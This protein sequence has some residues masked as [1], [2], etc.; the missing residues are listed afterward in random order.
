MQFDGLAKFPGSQ[1]LAAGSP[2]NCVVCNSP[3]LNDD[4]D[5]FLGRKLRAVVGSYVLRGA[6]FYKQVREVV[7]HIIGSGAPPHHFA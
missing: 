4:L 3:L 1:A 6:M 5:L 7:Q 2:M